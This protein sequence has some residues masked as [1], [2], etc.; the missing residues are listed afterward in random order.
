MYG[1]VWLAIGTALWA[2]GVGVLTIKRL[3]DLGMSGLHLIWI[4]LVNVAV[5]VFGAISAT[6]STLFAFVAFGTGLWLF[7]APS[8]AGPNFQPLS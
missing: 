2:W 3:H 7:F 6:L 1:P 4:W 8:K 5:P